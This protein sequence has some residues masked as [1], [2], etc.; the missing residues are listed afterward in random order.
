MTVQSL[1][2]APERA[3]SLQHLTDVYCILTYNEGKTKLRTQ[4]THCEGFVC[5]WNQDFK[6]VDIA[7]EPADLKIKVYN[8]KYDSYRD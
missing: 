3:Q 7:E 1:E 2:L 4:T 8:K 6:A 5:W